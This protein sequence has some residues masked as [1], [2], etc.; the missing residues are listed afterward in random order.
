MEI[1]ELRKQKLEKYI[2]VFACIAAFLF[3]AE[4]ILGWRSSVLLGKELE[5]MKSDNLALQIELTELTNNIAKIDPLKHRISE[6]SVIMR[7][8]GI[9][10]PGIRR[11][12]N[13]D[14]NLH[15]DLTFIDL[16]NQYQSKNFRGRVSGPNGDSSLLSNFNPISGGVIVGGKSPGLLLPIL[17]LNAIKAVRNGDEY[18]IQF[19]LDRTVFEVTNTKAAFFRKQ[20]LGLSPIYTRISKST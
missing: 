2:E 10:L 16:T 6:V 12:T 1:E 8:H 13:V 7:Y 11:G 9:F 15:A 3:M 14:T 18:V 20:V 5:R 19:E 4:A 17:E